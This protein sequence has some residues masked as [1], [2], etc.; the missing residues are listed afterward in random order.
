VP[1][2]N[3]TGASRTWPQVSPSLMGPVTAPLGTRASTVPLGLT[4]GVWS[5][6]R[7]P[8]ERGKETTVVADRSVPK[9]LTLDFVTPIEIPM[10]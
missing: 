1:T 4:T 6:V 10:Q 9:I 3:G 5:L 2:A 8:F 7:R